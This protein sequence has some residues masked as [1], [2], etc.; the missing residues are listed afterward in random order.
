[1][2][3]YRSKDVSWRVKCR[4]MVGHVYTVL[5]FGSESGSWSQAILDRITGWE[6]KAMRRLF[7][8]KKKEDENFTVYCQRTARA[9]RTMWAKRKLSF[10]SEV[11]VEKH[12]ESS[13]IDL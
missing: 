9:V 10:L 13:G 1:M 7:R 12:V 11:I 2:Q 6:T 3:I 5:C 4:R 8:F